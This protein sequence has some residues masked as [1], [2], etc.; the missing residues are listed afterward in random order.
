MYTGE[1]SQRSIVR[2]QLNTPKQQSYTL[3]TKGICL[4]RAYTQKALQIDVHKMAAN[5]I[6]LNLLKTIFWNAILILCE[7]RHGSCATAL[8]SM[9]RSVSVL[10]FLILL[11]E[12]V[13]NGSLPT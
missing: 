7:F 12:A 13:V 11:L 8:L 9:S 5:A 4:H 3:T 6:V 1:E 10:I 2:K